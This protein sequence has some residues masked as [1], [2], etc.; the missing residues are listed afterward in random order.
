MCQGSLWVRTHRLAISLLVH[1]GDVFII[2]ILFFNTLHTHQC[3]I[4]QYICDALVRY[5]DLFELHQAMS[6]ESIL[7]TKH[8][9]L[10]HSTVEASLHM[11]VTSRDVESVQFTSIH[12]RYCFYGKEAPTSVGVKLVV[13]SLKSIC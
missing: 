2:I 9:N 11:S 10:R 13:S 8:D 12:A 6:W 3:L 7:I 4:T 1:C 5:P